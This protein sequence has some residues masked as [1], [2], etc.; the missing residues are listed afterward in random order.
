MKT[1]PQEPL[2]I[3]NVEMAAKP[4]ATGRRIVSLWFPYWLTQTCGDGFEDGRPFALLEAQKSAGRLVALTP[5]AEA[6]GLYVGMAL[7]DARALVPELQTAMVSRAAAQAKLKKTARWLQRYTPWVGYDAPGQSQPGAFALLLDI[8]GC[9]HLFSGERAML[10]DMKAR[11][12][13]RGI[14]L[15]AAVAG[16]IG[17]AW[18][19]ARF[20]PEA[21]IIVLPPEQESDAMLPLPPAA[22]RLPPAHID[23]CERLGLDSIAA[24]ANFSRPALTR[25]FGALPVMRMEQAFGQAGEALSPCLPIPRFF[26][27]QSLPQGVTQIPA[28]TDLL[29]PLCQPLAAQLEAAGQGA[30]RLDLAMTRCD[31]AVL[32][33][34]LQLAS[35]S[36]SAGHMAS[37]FAD[38][39]ERLSS[40]IDA[41][42]GIEK[43]VLA[44]SQT[45]PLRAPQM[46]MGLHGRR[47]APPPASALAHLMDRLVGRL[48]AQRVVR[49]VAHASYIP[50]R[51]V[52]YVSVLEAGQAR[53]STQADKPDSVMDI[54][55]RPL[56]MLCAPEPIEVIA[57]VPEGAPYRFRWRRVLREVVAAQGPERISPEWWQEVFGQNETSH[58]RQTRDYFRVEDRHGHRFW[59]YRDGLYGRETQRPKWFMHGVFA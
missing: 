6:A 29:E 25:R 28:L 31:N 30:Q 33:L 4:R 23:L 7:A 10:E 42:F 49:P 55:T 13:A 56:F 57:E 41:G 15:R 44:A 5:L 46:A 34:S 18:G 37:L 22:L 17:A 43:L 45:S 47:H 51:A 52:A 2:T 48:G 3:S 32:A 59:L 35:P 53:A 50:E 26:V 19:L 21:D 11:F 36:V 58:N 12:E 27:Q 14:R 9:A 54:A 16:T 8:S 39:L 40:G 20:G 1:T 38:R 24:L